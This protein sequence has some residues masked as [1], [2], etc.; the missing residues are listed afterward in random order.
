VAAVAAQTL[1]EALPQKETGMQPP[2]GGRNLLVFSDNRQ[3]AAF[4]APFF[5]RTSREQAIRGAILATVEANG[6]I[7]IDNLTGA[8]ERLLRAQ[9]LRLYA[10]GVLPRL[11]TGVN[12]RQ[13]LKALIVAELTVFGRG[14]LSLEGFGLVG[15]DYAQLPRVVAMVSDKLPDPLKPFAKAYVLT[16]LRMMREHRAIA[17]RES[18]MIDLVDESIWTR[19][20]AQRDRC[21]TRERNPKAKLALR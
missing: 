7:D 1:L 17:E 18:G 14:R 8:V 4:F 21:F 16:L 13:R 11:E 6:R 20:A 15:V 10:P 5:E 3:D 12:E 9:G 19:I 2:M